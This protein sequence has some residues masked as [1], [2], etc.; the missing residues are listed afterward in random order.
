KRDGR[1]LGV[2][3]PALRRELEA[4]RDGVLERT[5]ADGPIL[6]DPRPSFD[7][8]AVALLPNLDVGTPGAG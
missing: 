1:L 2:D 3:V 4:S 7:D 6:P 5:L 8:L